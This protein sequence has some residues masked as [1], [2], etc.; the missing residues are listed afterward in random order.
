[1]SDKKRARVYDEA[2][3]ELL[4]EYESIAAAVE[5]F[6]PEGEPVER[7]R[8]QVQRAFKTG[9]AVMGRRV[10]VVRPFGDTRPVV[11]KRGKTGKVVKGFTSLKDAARYAKDEF[12]FVS[13][14]AAA[15]F[16]KEE[17]DAPEEGRGDYLPR[18]TGPL[19][20]YAMDIRFRWWD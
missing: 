8:A 4:G 11:M 17:C 12:K 1:M 18:S 20:V 15:R 7:I 3:K 5:S 13:P 9:G 14:V 10:V 19:M 16:I 2:T 6:R